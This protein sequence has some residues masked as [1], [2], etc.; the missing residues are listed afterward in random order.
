MWARRDVKR[1]PD[2]AQ[3]PY[4]PSETELPKDVDD[5]APDDVDD[6]GAFIFRLCV[7][8]VLIVGVVWYLGSRFFLSALA[9]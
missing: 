7:A 5:M 6:L 2:F 3:L 9:H 8:Y 1:P 4:T